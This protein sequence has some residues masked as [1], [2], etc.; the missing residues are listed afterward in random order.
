MLCCI[1]Y[2]NTYFFSNSECCSFYMPDEAVS[3][4]TR[5]PLGSIM[6]DLGGCYGFVMHKCFV[7]MC[8][9]CVYGESVNN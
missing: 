6:V 5:T 3:E 8:K 2:L 9:V 1:S 4:K 7:L